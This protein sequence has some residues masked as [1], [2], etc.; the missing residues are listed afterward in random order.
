M[1]F[2]QILFD[3][4]P[5][6]PIP[7]NFLRKNLRYIADESF[8]LQKIKVNPTSCDP[9]SASSVRILDIA[10]LVEK[11]GNDLS[12][13]TEAMFQVSAVS[14]LRGPEWSLIF[15]VLRGSQRVLSGVEGVREGAPFAIPPPPRA[16]LPSD[17]LL[18]APHA[19]HASLQPR[20]CTP[21][22]WGLP[23]CPINSTQG[24]T[25]KIA[26]KATPH[27]SVLQD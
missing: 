22:S 19:S 27:C 6:R 10:K 25:A 14:R 9:S 20:L 23:L 18:Q 17:L 7:L 4:E 21:I 12:M 8:G 16:L 3:T 11:F 15:H 1:E 2:D 5:H 24:R 26:T 13:W